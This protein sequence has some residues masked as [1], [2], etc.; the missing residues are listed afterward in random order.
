ML[1]KF[2]EE[3]T[4]AITLIYYC[5][6]FLLTF[7]VFIFGTIYL[8]CKDRRDQQRRQW[9]QFAER[10]YKDYNSLREKNIPLKMLKVKT[11]FEKLHIHS[12][13]TGLDVLRYWLAD[14]R[15]RNVSSESPPLR[16]LRG[17]LHVI[18]LQL[19]SCSSLIHLGAV[20]KNTKEEL[21]YV[22][23]ELGNLAKPFLA[24]EKL[25][26]AL[27]CLKHFSR[28]TPDAETKERVLDQRLEKIVP[29]VNSLKLAEQQPQ[30]DRWGTL[31]EQLRAQQI[32]WQISRQISIKF[33]FD[34]SMLNTNYNFLVG[35][36]KILEGEKRK[37]TFV[38]KLKDRH[39]VQPLNLIDPIG[40]RD[41]DELVLAKV[42]HE[43]RYY[44]HY[45]QNNGE[46]NEIRGVNPSDNIERLRQVY[47]EVT[48]SSVVKKTFKELFSRCIFDLKLIADNPPEHL[49]NDN[50]F[51]EFTK[52]WEEMKKTFTPEAQQR[53][54]QKVTY[55]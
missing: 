2:A 20:P 8:R 18:F 43:V 10:I 33:S 55:V 51:T 26:V 14:D 4:E 27:K 44:I 24:G 40:D 25:K 15:D 41:Y 32:S 31:I 28:D 46:L 7:F 36:H 54:N 19:N 21:K 11:T 42:L 35:L 38:R 47:I 52:L 13:V 12:T 45:V 23:E 6:S 1:Q 37:I 39:A 48:K 49:L 16:E 9:R 3:Y 53:R 50:F 22:V 30:T 29:Y 5:A 34:E 17:D